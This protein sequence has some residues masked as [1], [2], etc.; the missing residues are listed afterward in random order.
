M[1]RCNCFQIKLQVQIPWIVNFKIH[2]SQQLIVSFFLGNWLF[3]FALHFAPTWDGTHI[4]SCLGHYINQGRVRISEVHDEVNTSAIGWKEADVCR[5]NNWLLSSYIITCSLG[6]KRTHTEI[7]W[8]SYN[9]S[10]TRTLLWQHMTLAII[11][12]ACFFYSIRHSMLKMHDFMPIV[13]KA[14]T[15]KFDLEII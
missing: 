12:Y 10:Q 9:H 15:K 2:N 11:A 6:C 4:L 14:H 5:R 3:V 13:V 7:G 8:V 1:F